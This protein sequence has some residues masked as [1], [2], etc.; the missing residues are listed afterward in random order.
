M[1]VQYLQTYLG[2]VGQDFHA[3]SLHELGGCSVR[4]ASDTRWTRSETD[5]SDE[6]LISKWFQAISVSS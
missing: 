5:N 3:F 1:D 6:L 4:Y 2:K